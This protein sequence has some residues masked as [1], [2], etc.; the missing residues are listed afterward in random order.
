MCIQ[1]GRFVF[2]NAAIVNHLIRKF[3]ISLSLISLSEND[4]LCMPCND[5]NPADIYAT[6]LTSVEIDVKHNSAVKQNKKT[7]LNMF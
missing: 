1:V 6:S 7:C 3:N 2:A 4:V 5:R